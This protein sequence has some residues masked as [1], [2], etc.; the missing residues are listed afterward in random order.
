[1]QHVARLAKQELLWAA[2]TKVVKVVKVD[3]ERSRAY[4][5]LTTITGP[6]DLEVVLD[7]EPTAKAYQRL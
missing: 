4:A 3:R 2:G 5:E 6:E 1:M 7:A